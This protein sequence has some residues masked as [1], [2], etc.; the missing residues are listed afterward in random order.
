MTT[1]RLSLAFVLPLALLAF[2]NSC[3]DQPPTTP[4]PEPQRAIALSLA[5]SSLR[6]IWL[7]LSLPDSLAGRT[8]KLFRNDALLCQITL[9]RRD[10][11]VMDSGLALGASYAYRAIRYD[12]ARALD[13]A[14]LATAT[15]PAT[16]HAFAWRID[17]LG[18]TATRLNDVCVINDTCIWVVGYFGDQYNAARFDGHQWQYKR[19]EWTYQGQTGISELKSIF[20]FSQNDIWVGDSAPYHWDGVQWTVFNVTGLFDG[21]IQKF[22]GT[23]SRDLYAVGTNGA[24]MHY[25]GLAWRRVESG[26]TATINDVW[27]S[28]DRALGDM[29]ALAPTGRTLT[30]EPRQILRI[31]GLLVDSIAWTPNFW[32]QSVWFRNPYLLWAGGGGFWHRRLSGAW[33]ALPVTG[34]YVESVRGRAENDIFVVGHFGI[35]WHFNGETWQRYSELTSSIRYKSVAVGDRR[36][37]AVGVQNGRG[38]VLQMFR[39]Q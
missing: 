1:A 26:T 11:V 14:N 22:W 27:G 32:V 7:R 18:T 25:N 3:K 2:A 34:G 16:S 35:V 13:S 9:A 24:I 19:I 23:S 12:G 5:D 36:M 10:T 8:V 30:Q 15:M 6:E 39:A 29:L 37:C 17:T 20:A 21:Y 33:Q 31:K 4:T 28:I 38:Y